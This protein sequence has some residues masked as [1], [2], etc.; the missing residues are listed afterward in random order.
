MED[1][2]DIRIIAVPYDSGHPGLRMGAGPNHLLENGVGEGLQLRG[3]KPSVTSVR[4]EIEPPAEVATFMRG[5]PD[6]THITPTAAQAVDL[7]PAELF[8]CLQWTARRL[9]GRRLPEAPEPTRLLAHRP[10]LMMA[11]G[12]F[13]GALSWSRSLDP[14]TKVLVRARGGPRGGG[15]RRRC[16][17]LMPHTKCRTAPRCA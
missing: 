2:P 6:G 12:F 11:D 17:W 9:T 16:L 15:G 14:H 1:H 3:R 10:L 8:P 7:S 4:H 13:E 5:G